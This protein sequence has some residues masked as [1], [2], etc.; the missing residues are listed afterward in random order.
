M[1]ELAVW[2][3]LIL[4]KKLEPVTNFDDELA[5]FSELMFERMY[6]NRGVGLAANQVHLTKRMLVMDV[7]NNKKVCVN[8]YVVE[9]SKELVKD[10]EGCLSFPGFLVQVERP[11]WVIAGYQDLSGDIIEE[12]LEG[13]EARS[14]LHEKDHLDGVTFLRYLSRQ[15]RELIDKKM[16]KRWKTFIKE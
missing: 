16:R 5:F 11:S 14:F 6:Y 13:F 12:K 15:H 3:N 2:P 1:L 9:Q 4:K 10:E 7:N 8:P